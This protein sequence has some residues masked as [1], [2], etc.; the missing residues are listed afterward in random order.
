MKF[1]L[2]II[3]A[4]AIALN[5][6][7]Y[8]VEA[9]PVIGN[10]IDGGVVAL[11]AQFPYLAAIFASNANGTKKFC[12]GVL[13]N[14]ETVLTAAR[15]VNGYTNLE[16]VL[17][18]YR[19]NDTEPGQ[20]RL[21]RSAFDVTIHDRFEPGSVGY[22]V[23]LIDL[24]VSVRFSERIKAAP[25]IPKNATSFDFT[26]QEGSVVGWDKGQV[27][28]MIY[29]NQII[30]NTQCFFQVLASNVCLAADIGQNGPWT[31]D[32]GS[33][34][35]TEYNGKEAV[36]GIMAYTSI[37][38]PK[39]GRPFVFSRLTEFIKWIETNS[40]VEFPIVEA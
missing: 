29:S 37:Y 19:P 17:G 25:L 5:G 16:I 10:F 30:S 23:A 7:V 2:A 20:V 35:I 6:A 4:V 32:A 34:L 31:D 13:M 12:H 22:D 36:I 18:A 26:K 3:I 15:C 14:N 24:G 40:S 27:L 1:Q 9:D 33:P 21:P 8:N 28:V 38:G 11:P 39:D